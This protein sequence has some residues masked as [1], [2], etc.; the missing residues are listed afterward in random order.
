[1]KLSIYRGD[2]PVS[3][4]DSEST[5]AKESFMRSLKTN[6]TL[7][8]ETRLPPQIEKVSGKMIFLQYN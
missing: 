4:L 7:L 8:L 1:M 2:E 5:P 6:H 3:L